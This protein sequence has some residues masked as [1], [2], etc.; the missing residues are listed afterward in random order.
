MRRIKLKTHWLLALIPLAA[1]AIAGGV[2]FAAYASTDQ[3]GQPV[4]PAG[5]PRNK[6]IYLDCE[7]LWNFDNPVF[8]VWAWKGDSV[9]DWIEPAKT[10]TVTISGVANP[11]ILRIYELD[12]NKYDHYLFGRIAPDGWTTKSQIWDNSKVWNQSYNIADN[13]SYNYFQMTGWSTKTK[14]KKAKLTKSGSTISRTTLSSEI[15]ADDA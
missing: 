12:A 3:V 14:Y 11:V 8:Y 9:K 10:A 1:S 15:S 6:L 7:T 2:T 5:G 13:S 4:Y